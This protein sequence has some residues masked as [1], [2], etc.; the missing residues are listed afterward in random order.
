MKKPKVEKLFSGWPDTKFNK[1]GVRIS[2]QYFTPGRKQF[3]E[4]VAALF[5][6][7]GMG[8]GFYSG[9]DNETGEQALTGALIGAFVGSVFGLLL[10][11]CF[12]KRT[13]IEFTPEVIRVPSGFGF[14]NYDRNL[15]HGFN[16][17]LHE[18][19]QVE[20][21]AEINERYEKE[22]K[23]AR[24]GRQAPKMHRRGKY[25]RNSYHVFMEYLGERIYLADVFEKKK[26]EALLV[27]LQGVDQFM[28]S[29]EQAMA[30]HSGQGRGERSKEPASPFGERPPLDD[31]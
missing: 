31:E 4:I 25:Y 28:K 23:Y 3:A 18:K 21:E 27:R 1:N 16:A 29:G 26:A 30:P 13:E 12:K 7:A 6:L 11:T 17:V 8:L 2:A 10:G 14:K 24:Q 15:P 19:A 9:M 22:V 5:G 20:E